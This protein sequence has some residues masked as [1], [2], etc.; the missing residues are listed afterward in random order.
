M[1]SVTVS[2]LVK[3]LLDQQLYCR[4]SDTTDR[5]ILS[6]GLHSKE[7]INNLEMFRRSMFRHNGVRSLL[8]IIL[9]KIEWTFDSH[10]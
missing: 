10:V 3:K 8:G 1:T 9:N 6:Q 5:G 7:P 2:S 4:I